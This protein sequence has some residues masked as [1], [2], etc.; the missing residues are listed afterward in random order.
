[1]VAGLSASIAGGLLY[2]LSLKLLDWPDAAVVTLLL[3][4][5]LIGG[6]ESL[7]IT[8]GIAWALGLAPKNRSAKAI[9]WIGMAMFAAM[10]AGAPL[11]SFVFGRSGFGAIAI[12]TIVLSATGLLIACLIRPFVPEAAP[13][14]RIG[15]VLNAVALPGLG[16]ALSGLTF[17]AITSFLT[18]YFA[19][20][21]W[22]FGAIAFTSFAAALVLARI[23]VGHLPDMIGGARTAIYCLVLQVAGLCLI[24]M[25]GSAL[26]AIVGAALS[27]A[28]FSLV[29]PGL[30]LEAV[31]RAPPQARGMAM[32]VYNTF[33]DATLGFGS[34]AL[35][36]LAA[37]AGLGSVFIASAMASACAIPIAVHLS[38]TSR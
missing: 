36:F 10:A 23:T 16:F 21:N 7:I 37:H 12:A 14:A 13:R 9:S 3:G 19:V 30:G 11:G 6:A 35:G 1:M 18:L 4:R 33:L 26:V 38:R 22:P 17:G 27:G 8:G 24:G 20:Q 5:T 15:K 31:R 34:P 28:G 32:G 29:F 25:A 2:L